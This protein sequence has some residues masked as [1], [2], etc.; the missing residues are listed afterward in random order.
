MQILKVKT[1]IDSHWY[2][3][4]NNLKRKEKYKKDFIN[5][6]IK[7]DRGS[8]MLVIKYEERNEDDT[9]DSMISDIETFSDTSE[10]LS[11]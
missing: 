9:F 3:E 4:I 10:S 6:I 7:K 2:F 1:W 5:N 11:N 8:N